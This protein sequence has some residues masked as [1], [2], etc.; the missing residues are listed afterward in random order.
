MFPSFHIGAF[1]VFSYPLILGLIWGISYHFSKYLLE[2]KKIKIENFNYF[3]GLCF[4]SAWLGAKLLFLLSLKTDLSQ[5]AIYSP[6]FWL[7]GG[8]VFYG[9]L[10]GGG[11]LIV[12]F[13]KAKK[14]KLTVFEFVIPIVALGHS[15]GR[16]ACFLAG[17]CYGSSCDFPWSV[18]LHESFRHPVQLYEFALVFF[19]FLFLFSRF[20]KSKSVTTEYIIGYASI[21]FF[22]EFFRGDLIRG[23]FA[24]EL[25]TS[26]FISLLLLAIA[27]SYK[28]CTAR[29]K[30]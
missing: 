26:Q 6:G 30:V 22:L 5:R 23:I 9:G 20:K 3:Y 1:Q 8:F 21:R 18:F 28:Y 10:L 25:S 14:I 4:F 2:F 7:G 17:C 24:F 11:L 29:W 15:I 13:A 27:F 12:L 16:I 19:L